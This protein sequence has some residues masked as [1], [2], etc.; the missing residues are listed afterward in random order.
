[1]SNILLLEPDELLARTYAAAFEAAGHHVL[2]VMAA[3]GAIL[4]AD[5]LTPDVVILE[6]QLAV[7]NGIE[8]LH[9]FRSY[10][11]WGRIPVIVNTF[12][13]PQSFEGLRP[14]L[15]GDL[16]IRACLYKPHT[17]LQTLLRTVE[18]QLATP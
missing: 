2:R 10:T 13:H 4:A 3:E 7:H 15:Y 18:K 11:D 9:E 17:S 8:F 12:L 16:G 1:M 6:I 5:E 14:A